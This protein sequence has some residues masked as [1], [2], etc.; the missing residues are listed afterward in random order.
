M[1]TGVTLSVTHALDLVYDAIS[2]WKELFQ[3]IQPFKAIVKD[4][5]CPALCP[6][7]K[8]LQ[9]DF[10]TLSFKNGLPSAAAL[11]SRVVR[12]A[13]TLLLDFV[14]PNDMLEEF[15][16]IVTLMVHVLQ[17]DR[18]WQTDPTPTGGLDGSIVTNSA[19]SS[20]MSRLN[21]PMGGEH[22]VLWH[23]LIFFIQ[24]LSC[25]NCQ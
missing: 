8:G 25:W 10:L 4:Y 2:G 14:T 1:S 17:P 20:I 3:V 22:V 5:V 6:L 13:R 16:L 24:F 15:D 12:M 9:A 11:S 7:L 19:T 23:G 21:A 18:S